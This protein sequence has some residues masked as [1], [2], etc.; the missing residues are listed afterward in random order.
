M[1]GQP[2]FLVPVAAASATLFLAALYEMRR[3]RK[4]CWRRRPLA[5]LSEPLKHAQINE[6]TSD[7]SWRAVD[8]ATGA[9]ALRS[10]LRAITQGLGIDD[11]GTPLAAPDAAGGDAGVNTCT[12]YEEY[13][14]RGTDAVIPSGIY[15]LDDLK[16]L[17]NLVSF[18]RGNK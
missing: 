9:A 4:A 18:F 5:S 6:Y 16:D 11:S 14:E 12:F 10:D 15:S 3:R 2:V 7:D 1:H 17:G 8:A 13:Q